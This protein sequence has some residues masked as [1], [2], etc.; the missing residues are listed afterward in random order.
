MR[1]AAVRP[2]LYFRKRGSNRGPIGLM[3]SWILL[4]LLYICS[5][6]R[7]TDD[8]FWVTSIKLPLAAYL[9]LAYEASRHLTIDLRQFCDR[10]L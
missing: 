2:Y 1:I 6:L 8:L 7:I 3:V 10:D 4:T 5:T 9:D